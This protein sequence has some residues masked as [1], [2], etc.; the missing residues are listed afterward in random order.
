MRQLISIT[1]CFLIVFALCPSVAAAGETIALAETDGSAMNE[2]NKNAS[3]PLGL[4]AKDIPSDHW[5]R[6]AIETLNDHKVMLGY[7]GLFRPDDRITRAEYCALI[8][9]AF[10]YFKKGET[11]LFKDSGHDSE[12]WKDVEIMKAAYQGY[13]KGSSG[14]ALPGRE[15]TREEAMVIL[16]R[17]LRQESVADSTPF[18]DEGEV[19]AWAKPLIAAL[20]KEGY[21]SGN[22]GLLSP[23]AAITRAETAQLLYSSIGELLDKGSLYDMENKV[24]GHVT[25]S[26]SDVVLK[27]AVIKG[28]LYITEGVGDGAVTLDNV[29]VEGRTIIAGGGV[30]SVIIIN[31]ELGR[32]VIDV[33][34]GASV[35]FAAQ[36]NSSVDSVMVFS[37][38]I[39]DATG[40]QVGIESVVIAIP[41][42]GSVDLDGSFGMVEIETSS[43]TV[44]A[45]DGVID[46]LIVAGTALDA[47]VN[48]HHTASVGSLVCDAQSQILGGGQINSAIINVNDVTLEQR[49][50]SLTMP[51]GIGAKVAG[52]TQNSGYS[53]TAGAAAAV[54]AFQ[55]IYTQIGDINS[56]IY[57]WIVENG[58]RMS[59]KAFNIYYI[60]PGN[61]PNPENFVTEICYPIKK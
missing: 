31:T 12:K 32:A 59:G 48:L 3:K 51:R 56:Y 21:I 36:G 60:S 25:I 6:K 20:W 30:H 15:I 10:G 52:Q 11:S 27:N 39:I 1:L 58:Y 40:S 7:Q 61:E 14:Y 53:A 8:N 57:H 22:G 13:L 19:S 41:E 17:L 35:R 16:S 46:Q 44:N 43:L 33:P 9:R 55:G 54:V 24:L 38:S 26:T 45:R 4:V 18:S 50:E 37:D 42:G 2:E 5:A 29:K 47:E 49:P 28:N 23:K 34:D